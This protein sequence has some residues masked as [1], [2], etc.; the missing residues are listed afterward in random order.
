MYPLPTQYAPVTF[1]DLAT[2]YR[3]LAEF[4]ASMPSLVDGAAMCRH[5]VADVSALLEGDHG[6][7]IKL[8]DAATRTGFSNGH[9]RRMIRLGHLRTF[10]RGRTHYVR[11]ADLRVK[12]GA[13]FVSEPARAAA[14]VASPPSTVTN[15]VQP[16][17]TSVRRSATSSPSVAVDAAPVARLDVPTPAGYDADADARQMA[18]TRGRGRKF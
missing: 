17:P 6:T 5:I 16:D 1:D 3:G 2:K 11:L 14:E 18:A 7:L 13:V 8:S 12:K 15:L 9:L 10:R 4:Y